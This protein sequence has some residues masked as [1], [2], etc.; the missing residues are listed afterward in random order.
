MKEQSLR[1]A[2]AQRAAVRMTVP[3]ALSILHD[4]LALAQQQPIDTPEVRTALAH[5]ERLMKD[6]WPVR[7]ARDALAMTNP[8]G[9]WQNLNASINAIERAWD[10]RRQLG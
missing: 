5:V 2:E 1:Q 6:P 9:R 4:A 8:T 10:K 3:L 7:Q